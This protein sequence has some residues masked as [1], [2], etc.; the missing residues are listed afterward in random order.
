MIDILFYLR[1]IMRCMMHHEWMKGIFSIV[2]FICVLLEVG[3]CAT[4]IFIIF[5]KCIKYILCAYILRACY[6][7]IYKYTPGN[8]MCRFTGCDT[9]Y[10]YNCTYKSLLLKSNEHFREKKSFWLKNCI[11]AA[12]NFPIFWAFWSDWSH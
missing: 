4:F 6:W 12:V 10:A 9:W 1:F 2:N 7:C 3:N 8:Y 11:H 5:I